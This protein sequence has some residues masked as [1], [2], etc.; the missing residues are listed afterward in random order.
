[1]DFS[2]RVVPRHAQNHSE[3]GLKVGLREPSLRE[4]ARGPFLRVQTKSAAGMR[5][6]PGFTGE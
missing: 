6:H 5:D 3:P 4:D 2:D 1:M